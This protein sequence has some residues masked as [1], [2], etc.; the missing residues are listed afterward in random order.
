MC[1]LQLT[2]GS[3]AVAEEATDLEL[4]ALVSAPFWNWIVSFFDRLSGFDLQTFLRKF[5]LISFSNNFNVQNRV[6]LPINYRVF[7]YPKELLQKVIGFLFLVNLNS[8]VK[9]YN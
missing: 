8:W 9:L 1:H 5:C 4:V 2:F 6:Q 3:S 7:L